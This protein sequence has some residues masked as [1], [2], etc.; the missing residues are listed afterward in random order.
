M[1]SFYDEMAE[2]ISQLKKEKILQWKLMQCVEVAA[3]VLAE[4]LMQHD[5]KID[6]ETEI[7]TWPMGETSQPPQ[8][9]APNAKGKGEE[10]QP[11]LLPAQLMGKIM[12]LGYWSIRYKQNSSRM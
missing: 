3:A 12:S 7:I 11:E 2:L 9:K 10:R 6:V 8:N 4:V 5:V 1:V